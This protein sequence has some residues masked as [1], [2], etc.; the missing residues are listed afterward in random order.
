MSIPLPASKQFKVG[1]PAVGVES[2]RVRKLLE[3]ALIVL[4]V[5]LAAA[6]QCARR[7]LNPLVGSWRGRAQFQYAVFTFRPNE[8]F[9]MQLGSGRQT[10][11]YH[12]DFSHRPAE[13]T[14][15]LTDQ[16]RRYHEICEITAAGE[17]RLSQ[18]L[19]PGQLPHRFDER[20]VVFQRI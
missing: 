6:W 16:G 3:L 11:T 20:T 10:G 8:S 4:L 14:L 1:D 2:S 9:E 15:C 12:V 19:D 18:G 7:P 17:L 5:G 13:L